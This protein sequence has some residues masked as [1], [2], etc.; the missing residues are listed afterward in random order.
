MK[1]LRFRHFLSRWLFVFHIDR[2]ISRH[3]EPVS[4]VQ[5]NGPRIISANAENDPFVRNAVEFDKE[6]IHDLLAK[7]TIA[8]ISPIIADCP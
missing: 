5:P 2:W 4:F 7:T 1:D 3:C 8:R 6:D